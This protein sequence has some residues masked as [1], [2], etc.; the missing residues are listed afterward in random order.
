MDPITAV[1]TAWTVGSNAVTL[2]KGAAEQAKALGK[3]EIISSLIDVQVAMMEVLGEQQKLVDENRIL[4]EKIR[5]LEEIIETKRSLEF[6]HNTYWSRCEDGSLD[7]PY[8]TQDW[9]KSTK[10]VRL[11]DFGPDDF[12]GVRK[13][14]F[15]N[16]GNKEN[17]YVP[18]SFLQKERV[19]AYVSQ[20]NF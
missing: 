8:S 2:L 17:V 4:R 14:H 20:Q 18:L 12:D 13:V 6:H 5:S 11:T 7:G 16:A 19:R 15:Y 1:S 9:D 10:M 3:S